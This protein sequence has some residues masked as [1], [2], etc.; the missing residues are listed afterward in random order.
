VD[1]WYPFVL[2]AMEQSKMTYF[3]I[4][5]SLPEKWAEH[6]GVWSAPTPSVHLGRD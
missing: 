3:S 6:P 5:V 4:S 2:S 1:C